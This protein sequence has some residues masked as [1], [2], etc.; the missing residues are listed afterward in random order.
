MPT[1]YSNL[2][3]ALLF[4]EKVLKRRPFK[5]YMHAA[6]DFCGYIWYD[7]TLGTF[8]EEVWQLHQKKKT[9]MNFSLED[10]IRETNDKFGD[11]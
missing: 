4:E 5:K 1:L 9:L 10:L 6:W 2:T 7:D 8:V 11:E 3:K